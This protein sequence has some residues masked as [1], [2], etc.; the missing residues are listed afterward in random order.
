[1]A[2][3]TDGQSVERGVHAA[4]T[5]PATR[6]VKRAEAR[7]PQ[8]AARPF[9]LLDTRVI[10]CGDNLELPGRMQKEEGRMMK[11]AHFPILHSSFILLNSPVPASHYVKVMLD[12]I[13]GENNFESGTASKAHCSFSAGGQFPWLPS[14]SRQASIRWKRR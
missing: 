1:M 8:A 5:P 2:K 9:S 11:P 13:F 3:K 6:T 10:Y 4:S 7:A 12:Q 14:H